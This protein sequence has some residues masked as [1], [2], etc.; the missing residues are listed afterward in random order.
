ML[1]QFA[2]N[3]DPLLENTADDQRKNKKK[4]TLK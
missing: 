3:E 2:I 4:R 1:G